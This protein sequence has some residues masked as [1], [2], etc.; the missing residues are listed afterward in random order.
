M[1]SAR[2]RLSNKILTAF[3]HACDQTDLDV[4]DQLVRVLES[5]I[6]RADYRRNRNGEEGVAGAYRR[7][8]DLRHGINSAQVN[9]V[10][11]ERFQNRPFSTR[12]E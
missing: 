2:R 5:V 8:W 3:H 7:L 1:S 12:V 6:R 11:A 4:A 10:P 9:T